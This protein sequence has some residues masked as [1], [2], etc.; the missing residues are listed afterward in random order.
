MSLYLVPLFVKQELGQISYR[1]Q[2]NF[3]NILWL[4]N[5]DD[6]GYSERV[7]GHFGGC[8]KQQERNC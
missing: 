1:S 3:E 4:E 8:T 7:G 2:L 6:P 5:S